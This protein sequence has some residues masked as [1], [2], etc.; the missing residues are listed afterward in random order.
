MILAIV[1]VALIGAAT[2]SWYVLP[3]GQE[4]LTQYAV[5]SQGGTTT[6]STPS[7]I[8]KIDEHLTIDNTL[9]DVNFC[10]TTYR[11]KQVL[12]DGVDVVQRIAELAT[13]KKQV[14][15]VPQYKG[16]GEICKKIA[17]N[18]L[19]RAVLKIETRPAGYIEGG[20]IV[21]PLTIDTIS[22]ITSLAMNNIAEVGGPEF[23]DPGNFGIFIP[24]GN[25]K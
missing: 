5:P 22:F 17:Q 7:T 13:E 25:L 11:A 8:E 12:L 2:I 4:S 16:T 20:E 18:N 14:P 9:R 3:R 24:I 1:A 10:G 19:E 21:Y 6:S 15:V 23:P